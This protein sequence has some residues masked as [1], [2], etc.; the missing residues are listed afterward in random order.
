MTV[1]RWIEKIKLIQFLKKIKGS[2]V[3]EDRIINVM[4]QFGYIGIFSLI[5]IENI[6][7]PI[8][9]EIILAFGG[10]MTTQ[11]EMNY[12]MRIG[13]LGQINQMVCV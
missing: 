12:F 8:P 2:E 5:L 6:F 13:T 10:F 4:Q 1:K 7:P 3:M 9:S 11:T